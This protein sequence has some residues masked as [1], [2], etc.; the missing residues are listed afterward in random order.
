MK[1]NASVFLALT[2]LMA[3]PAHAQTPALRS[4]L[5]IGLSQYG[6]NTGAAT[7]EGVPHDM[8][9]A[10][11]I[12]MAMGIPGNQIR[13]MRDQDATKENI[14]KEI[15]QLGER[16]QEGGRSFIYFSGHGT[17][18]WDPTA[19]GC[20]EGLLTHDGQAITNAELAQATQKVTAGADKVI[21]MI[22]AC[23]SGGVSSNKAG[24]RSIGGVEFKPKFSFKASSAADACSQPSNLKTRSLLGEATRL[25]ALQENVVQITSSRPDEVSFDEPGKG[26]LATQGVR[27][28]L[29]GKAVDTDGSGAVSLAEIQQC[30]QAFIEQRLKGVKDLTPHHVSVSGNRNLIPVAQQRPTSTQVAVAAVAPSPV[31]VTP[32]ATVT[33]AA[34]LPAPLAPPAPPAKPPAA[35]S[36]AQNTALAATAPAAPAAP[37]SPA[38]TP[39]APR[40]PAGATKPPA[41]PVVMVAQPA[42]APAQPMAQAVATPIPAPVIAAPPTPAPTPAIATPEPMLASLA[43]LT[44]IVQQ[45][46]PR[47]V[48][49]VKLSKPVLK[50]GKDALD[51]S[52]QSSHDGYIYLV[53]LGS[54]RKSFYVLYPNGLDKDNRIKAGQTRKL[55]RPD[56]Q[57]EAAGPPGIDHLLVMVASSPRQ[58]DRLVMTAPSATNPFTY[59]LNEIGGRAA[60]INFLVHN[61]EGEGSERF[62][63]KLLTLKEVL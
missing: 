1:K 5:V 41:A 17:R 25:G 46:D 50:I 8:E 33:A 6:P 56:W 57:L 23:H 28:C 61:K 2:L 44:D 30:A 19:K 43:T 63:A 51:L 7:L 21:T 47:I 9:S 4:A 16:T 42:P 54:D 36:V 39:S 22:D 12:A 53:L 18:Y 11:R 45:R 48:L 59:A 32:A 20:V 37:T 24:T 26:G 13:M 55:P 15:R 58:I 27:D 35:A 49:D 40:P 3:W 34:T 60:L 14:L 62:G 38:Q 29:L 10:K 31:L 52:I